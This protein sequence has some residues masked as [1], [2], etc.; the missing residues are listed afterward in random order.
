MKGY[1]PEKLTS[2]GER[3]KQFCDKHPAVVFNAPPDH[4][5]EFINWISRRKKIP[6]EELPKESLALHAVFYQD[7]PVKKFLEKV[8]PGD[9]L[10]VLI[11]DGESWVTL[12]VRAQELYQ[13]GDFPSN[14]R[15]D[16]HHTKT[17]QRT[18]GKHYALWSGHIAA[19]A[20]IRTLKR[21]M[22][23]KDPDMKIFMQ[24]A[25]RYAVDPEELHRLQLKIEVVNV[26]SPVVEVDH[27]LLVQNDIFMIKK[28]SVGALETGGGMMVEAGSRLT[29]KALA[30]LEKHPD[31]ESVAITYIP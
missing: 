3:I 4:Q 11:P 7:K 29:S 5:Q 10:L 8:Q 18:L 12:L 9:M 2:E 19:I 14:W 15:V 6:G 28:M 24:K 23:W 20:A 31:F 30:F 1:E 27:G 22:C 13:D 26:H 25:A 21:E 16:F 17:C